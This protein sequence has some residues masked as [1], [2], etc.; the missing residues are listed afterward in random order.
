MGKPVDGAIP[1]VGVAERLEVS[2]IDL[3]SYRKRIASG[4]VPDVLVYDRL[5]YTLRVQIVHI[6]EESI[7]I[8][9]PP[10][11]SFADDMSPNNNDAWL[12]IHKSFAREH[13]LFNL[14]R[15]LNIDEQCKNFLLNETS[16]DSVLD[17]IEIS[18]R[19][20]EHIPRIIK[21]PYD[22]RAK[23]ISVDATDAIGELNERFRR[24]SVGYQF[25]NGRIDLYRLGTNS[26]GSRTAST[27]ISASSGF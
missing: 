12:L 9:R 19:C 17:L 10:T 11:G 14:T 5:P 3:Y 1:L 20:I 27:S 25:E 24:A 26:L 15:D 13:G 8:F 22:R 6:W 7:G 18:F 23:G 21:R 4:E 2:V 16:V